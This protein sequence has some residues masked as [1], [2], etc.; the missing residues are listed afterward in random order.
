LRSGSFP[1]CGSGS[2][3]GAGTLEGGTDCVSKSKAQ[4]KSDKKRSTVPDR[5]PDPDPQHGM[6]QTAIRGEEY[7]LKKGLVQG[8]AIFGQAIK[9]TKIVCMMKCESGSR[10]RIQ[11]RDPKFKLSIHRYRDNA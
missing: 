11:I 4:A 8:N 10:G 3:S 9:R 7:E 5:D 6:I 2:G 1:G